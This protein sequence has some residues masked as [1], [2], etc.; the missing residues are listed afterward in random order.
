MTSKSNILAPIDLSRP[1]EEDVAYALCVAE[2]LGANLHLLYVVNDDPVRGVIQGWP[3]NAL[4]NEIGGISVSRAVLQGPIPRTIAEYADSIDADIVVMSSRRYGRWQRLWRR[5]VTEAVMRLSRRPIC[6][7]S[8]KAT[9]SDFRFRNR[10]ILCLVGLD[11]RETTLMRN[12]EELSTQT[13]SDLALLHVVPETS[14]ALLYHAVDGGSRPLS[15]QR[16]SADL[17]KVARSL[18][19]PSATSAMVGA[20]DACVG[21]VV[22]DQPVDL[23]MVSRARGPLQAAYGSELADILSRLRCPLLTVPVDAPASATS[24]NSSGASQ[25][26]PIVSTA[27]SGTTRRL[28]GI[29]DTLHVPIPTARHSIRDLLRHGR[30]SDCLIDGRSGY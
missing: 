18:G 10:R 17:N 26:R 2:S 30:E 9:D 14:E 20:P 16:A 19:L 1:S 25:R 7:T 23:V 13:S 11:D 12:A 27:V 4:T 15:K 28:S 21:L 22:R 29:R 24:R 6:I 5:S 3:L 8:A